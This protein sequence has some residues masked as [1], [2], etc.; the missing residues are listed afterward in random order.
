MSKNEKLGD[1]IDG[2]CLRFLQVQ[3]PLDQRVLL[4]EPR[5]SDTT[6]FEPVS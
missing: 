5:P 2:G 1:V 3:L 4:G 6:C